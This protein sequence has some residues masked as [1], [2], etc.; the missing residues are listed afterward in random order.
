[1]W[2]ASVVVVYDSEVGI[3]AIML[4]WKIL[5]LEKKILLNDKVGGN[6]Y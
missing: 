1:L 5:F 6:I 4:F 2:L 3:F